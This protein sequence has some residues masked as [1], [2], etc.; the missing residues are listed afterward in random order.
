[1][2]A[3]ASGLNAASAVMIARTCGRPK[4]SEPAETA[5]AE[6]RRAIFQSPLST[7]GIW[8]RLVR[9]GAGGE[10]AGEIPGAS[11]GVDAA[12]TANRA[13]GAMTDEANISAPKE[14]E[15]DTS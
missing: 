11:D 1:M 12:T 8:D 3:A 13:T 7:V 2:V 6:G 15:I 9:S 4:G 5:A 14:V 10:A